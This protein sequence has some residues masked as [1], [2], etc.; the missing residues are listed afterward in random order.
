MDLLSRENKF[1][2]WKTEGHLEYR[3]SHAWPN[4]GRAVAEAADVKISFIKIIC[5]FIQI[6]DADVK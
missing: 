6:Q 3:G 1:D 4:K 5:S 2:L